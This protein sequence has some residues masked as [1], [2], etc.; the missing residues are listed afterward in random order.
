MN[1]AEEIINQFD[2]QAHPEGG[3]Y[4]ETYRSNTT[5]S[6]EDKERNSSTAIYYL[7]AGNNFSAFHRIKSD[8][9]WHFYSG[10]ILEI[11]EITADGILKTHLLGS[12]YNISKPQIVIAAGNWFAARLYKENSMAF[13]GCT[14]SPG[15]DF[16]DFEIAK[17]QQLLENYPLF[18]KEIIKLTRD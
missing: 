10:D 12:D 17:R 9:M 6:I 8:E 13:V 16:K 2:L 15:F 11:I 4:K 14:V 1:T 7:L 18:E 3:Y 5:T